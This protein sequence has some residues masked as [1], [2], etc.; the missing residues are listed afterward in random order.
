MI[1]TD[2]FNRVDYDYKFIEKDIIM[3]KTAYKYKT[4]HKRPYEINQTWTNGTVTLQKGAK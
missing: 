3:N 2:F 4:P 1:I